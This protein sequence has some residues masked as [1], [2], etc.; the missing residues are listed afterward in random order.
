MMNKRQKK[1]LIG[2]GV[3]MVAMLLF[4]PFHMIGG[5]GR[6]VNSGYHFIFNP[7]V[8]VAVVNIGLLLVQWLIVAAVGFIGWYVLK[9]KE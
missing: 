6:T 9:S 1:F 2:V 8:I 7:P 3:A 5:G 4:P